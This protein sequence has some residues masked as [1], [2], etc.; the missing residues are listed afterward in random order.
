VQILCV[1]I[2]QESIGQQYSGARHG[3]LPTELDV[4]LAADYADGVKWQEH[5]T[6]DSAVLVGKPVVKG[7]RIAVE[8]VVDL[9]GRGYSVEQVLK[10]YDHLTAEDVQACLAYAAEVLQA[11]KVY[12]LR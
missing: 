3:R 6:I 10:Q 1:S 11:E 8:L 4:V 7:T 12:A 5:I 2:A 9:L